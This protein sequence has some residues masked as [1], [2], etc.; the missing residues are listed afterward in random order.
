MR[1]FLI[2]LSIFLVPAGIFLISY[3]FTDPFQIFGSIGANKF[4]QVAS[5]DDY[6]GIERFLSNVEDGNRYSAFVFGNSKTLA[7]DPSLLLLSQTE[8]GYN[9]GAPGECLRNIRDKLLLIESSGQNLDRALFILDHKILLNENNTHPFFQGPVYEHH[10]ASSG[11][12]WLSFHSAYLQY[13]IKGGFFLDYF[14]FRMMGKWDE[15]MLGKIAPEDVSKSATYN[16]LTN[17][18][19]RAGVEALIEKNP[20]EYYAQQASLNAPSEAQVYEHVFSESQVD[21]LEEINAI[22]IRNKC[23]YHV[24][25]GP[26]WNGSQLDS[27]V[28]EIFQEI[29]GS[30]RVR[31]FS[32]KSTWSGKRSFWYE[33]NHYRPMVGTEILKEVNPS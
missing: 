29:F 16:P 25:F 33:D 19:Q 21:L 9:F 23:N 18:T 31:D 28:L 22:M 14:R 24:I 5:S 6:Y 17:H 2:R 32:G 27:A 3:V 7:F 20:E 30:D 11:N 26:Y 1:T 12:T 8:L 10:P 15:G 4:N 13:F